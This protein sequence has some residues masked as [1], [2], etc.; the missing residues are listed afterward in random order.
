MQHM[1]AWC[2][3]SRCRFGYLHKLFGWSFLLCRHCVFFSI[4]FATCLAF[5][6]LFRSITMLCG[7]IVYEE[8]SYI[9]QCECRGIFYKIMSIPQ[10]IVMDLNKVKIVSGNINPL[11]W[12]QVMYNFWVLVFHVSGTACILDN[13]IPN[14]PWSKDYQPTTWWSLSIKYKLSIENCDNAP[15]PPNFTK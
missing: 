2:R 3:C 6:T 1:W 10:N 5:I 9:Y 8:Y 15:F 12:P 7:L 4:L 11:P 14:I 13:G